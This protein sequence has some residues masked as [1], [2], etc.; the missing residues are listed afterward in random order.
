MEV[1]LGGKKRINSQNRTPNKKLM[2]KVL[3]QTDNMAGD[4]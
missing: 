3:L 4:T 1:S 2:N